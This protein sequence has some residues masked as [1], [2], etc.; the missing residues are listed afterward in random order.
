MSPCCTSTELPRPLAGGIPGE[1]GARRARRRGLPAQINGLALGSHDHDRY[2]RYAARPAGLCRTL[3]EV[4]SPIPRQQCTGL[5]RGSCEVKIVSPVS[6]VMFSV[7]DG[8]GTVTCSPV[9]GNFVRVSGEIRCCGRR[10]WRHVRVQLSRRAGC[11]PGGVKSPF[12]GAGELHPPGEWRTAIAGVGVDD[13]GDRV[14]LKIED[15]RQPGIVRGHK[16]DNVGPVEVPHR[17]ESTDI[18]RLLP[19][20]Q[21]MGFVVGDIC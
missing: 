11:P 10:G 15:D 18:Y 8:P 2:V 14:G 5:R 21:C 7:T 9:S 3:W 6:T 17:V 1:P 16:R 4:C 19:R 13:A 12:H 20:Q